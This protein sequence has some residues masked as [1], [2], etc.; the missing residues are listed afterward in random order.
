MDSSDKRPLLI[1]GKSRNPHCFRGVQQLPTPYTNNK[2]A[3]MTSDIFRN[4]L[5]DFERDMAKKNCFIA[6]IVDNCAA[7]PKDSANNLP[8]IKLVFLPPNVT[9]LIQP[10]DMGIIR[11]LMANYRR[12]IV[13]VSSLAKSLTLLDAIHILKSAWEDLKHSSIMNCFAK[14]G[15]LP[16]CPDQMDLDEPPDGI[17]AEEFH[18][19]WI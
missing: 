3:W 10:C 1:I 5:F 15:F 11:N 7:H 17:S 13:I 19:L 6:L 8:H 18:T 2:N 4:W 14:A 12:K 9:S 16:Y